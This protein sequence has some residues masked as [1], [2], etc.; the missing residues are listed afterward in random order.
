MEHK[1]DVKKSSKGK[2]RPITCLS[3]Y[4]REMDVYL[5]T[6]RKLGARRWSTARSGRF[7]PRKHDVSIIQE[8][9]WASATGRTGT[10][11]DPRTVQPLWSHCT[12]QG[13]QIKDYIRV[14][15]THTVMAR[16][17]NR[18]DIQGCTG[19]QQNMK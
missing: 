19:F 11:I 7:V 17:L 13:C 14:K 2:G 3:L 12:D 16:V 1:T 8:V 10:G 4:R 5:Q 15:I 18:N 6:I 9:G